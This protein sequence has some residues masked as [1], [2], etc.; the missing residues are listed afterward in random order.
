MSVTCLFRSVKLTK[1]ADLDK[2]RYSS[3]SIGFDSRSEFSFT[4]GSMGKN[5]FIFVADMNSSVHTDNKNK[6]ILILGEGTT[7]GL[8]DTTLTAKAKYYVNFI[9]LR[10]RFV[11]TLHYNL[12]NSFFFVKAT[13]IYQFKAKDSQ[14]KNYALCLGNISK[15]FTINNMKKQY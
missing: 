2:W 4:D 6:D 8:D 5:V 10:K 1:N 7:Q 9:H 14:T 11:W 12:N 3:N 15:D 13:K